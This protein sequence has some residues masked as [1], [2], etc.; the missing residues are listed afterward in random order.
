[1]LYPSAIYRESIVSC[2]ILKLHVW[3]LECSYCF[4]ICNFWQV[5]WNA[6]ERP[7]KFQSNQTILNTNLMVLTFQVLTMRCLLD[8]EMVL[9]VLNKFGY[10][11]ADAL[12]PC[13]TRSSTL[14]TIQDKLALVFKEVRFSSM[15]RNWY[16]VIFHAS[17]KQFMALTLCVVVT[18]FGDIDLGH[19]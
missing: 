9:S 10:I 6:A 17:P 1:M 4:V 7:A 15:A 13:V 12:A 19:L 3:V 8:I 16:T 14:L 2:E 11:V 18:P 5:A